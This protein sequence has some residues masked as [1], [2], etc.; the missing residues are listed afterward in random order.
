MASPMPFFIAPSAALIEI[1]QHVQLDQI[2][3]AG[4][5]ELVIV[6]AAVENNQE[7]LSEILYGKSDELLEIRLL[8]A[9]ENG[10]EKITEIL[11]S[12]DR[13]YDAIHI[14]SHGDLGSVRLGDEGSLER[15]RHRLHDSIG[16]VG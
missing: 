10:V 7:L 1:P 5:R 2:D 3:F 6:D 13:P 15:Q 11:A 14:I 4:R 9:N 16:I 12:S 8:D